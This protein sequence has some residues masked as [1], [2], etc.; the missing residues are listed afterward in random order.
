MEQDFGLH[1]TG[2]RRSLKTPGLR[3]FQFQ[4]ILSPVGRWSYSRRPF[5][6][7]ERTFGAPQRKRVFMLQLVLRV[8]STRACA[9]VL[10]RRNETG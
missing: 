1:T 9:R 3:W 6:I 5:L 2:E 10:H 7:I 4:S 8:G